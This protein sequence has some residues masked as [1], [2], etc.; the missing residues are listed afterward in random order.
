M[1]EFDYGRCGASRILLDTGINVVG[2]TGAILLPVEKV[3]ELCFHIEY[4]H[5]TPSAALP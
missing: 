3:L 5:I 4:F 1:R 2:L